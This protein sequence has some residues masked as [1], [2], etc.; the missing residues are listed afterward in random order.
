MKSFHVSVSAEAFAA[1][2]FAQAGYDVSVQYGANQP[3]YD[4]LVSKNNH[5]LKVS[6][7]GTQIEGWGLAQTYKQKDISYHAAI[8]LWKKNHK[9]KHVIYCFVQLQN[10]QLGQM[11]KVYLSTISEISKH[12][13]AQRG[14]HAH[15]S[16]FVEHT[17]TSG[18]AKGITDK[19]P[20]DWMFS[21]KRIRQLLKSAT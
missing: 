12:L 21:E 9:S 4:L 16:L 20:D 11:P 13:K 18:I 1:A 3:E 17:Y 19:I 10:G 8:D 2:L 14:G 5:I 6:V 7:K 15:C